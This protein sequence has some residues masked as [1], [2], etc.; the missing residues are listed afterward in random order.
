MRALFVVAT[1]ASVVA[2]PSVAGATPRALPFTYTTE[3]LGEGEAE[4]EQ[5]ADVTPLR[6][7]STS[8]GAPVW[9]LGTQLLT[10]LEYGLGG[11]AELGLYF[12]LLPAPGGAYT[13]TGPMIE[14]NGTKQRLRYTF[15]E[16]GEWPIDVG[17]YGEL[18]ENDHEIEV[19]AKILL[20]RR[21][22]RL[23]IDVNLWAEYEVYYVPQRDIVLNPTLGAT[24]ELAPS[25]HVG[26]ETWVRAELPDPAPHPRPYSVG[27]AAYVGP[28]LLLAFAKL[29]WSTGVYGRVSE[30]A[31]AMQPGEPYGPVWV[32]TMIGFNL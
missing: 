17:A 14:G 25:V 30:P 15:A 29:W 9:Y 32:R 4:L 22:G 21:L 27:P 18:A 16:P 7:L 24:Y 19:E 5:Y 20:Q 6:A 23:R 2:L 26:A 11:R 1:A 28:A 3:T 31:H 12:T 8:S 10:E 13:S